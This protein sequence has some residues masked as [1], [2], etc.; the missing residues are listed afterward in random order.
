MNTLCWAI[1][2]ISGSNNLN[3]NPLFVDADGVDNIVGTADDDLRLQAGSPGINQASSSVAN[4]EM[5]DADGSLR[6]GEP[7]MGAFE[8]WLA[9]HSFVFNSANYEI[10]KQNST[11][12][13]HA[14]KLR[15]RLLAFV[16]CSQNYEPIRD[17]VCNYEPI[18]KAITN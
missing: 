3:G 5:A 10:I 18:L 11:W 1:G 13:Q 12:T 4:Y 7:D 15:D 17:L 8:Y 6:A 16:S 14:N 2:S 9:P